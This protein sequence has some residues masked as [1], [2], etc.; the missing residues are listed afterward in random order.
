MIEGIPGTASLPLFPSDSTLQDA[1]A[2]QRRI[3]AA[4]PDKVV[5]FKAAATSAAA[6]T[7]LGLSGPLA[8]ALFENGQVIMSG[9]HFEVASREGMLLETEIGYR[10]AVDVSY[11]VLTAEQARESVEAML[12]VIEMPVSYAKRLGVEEMSANQL[13]AVNIGSDRF[14]YGEGKA[15]SDIDGIETLKA[16]LTHDGEELHHAGVEALKGGQWETLRALMNQITD[17]GLT[18]PAG[19]VILSGALGKPHPVAPGTYEADYGTLGKVTFAVS[20]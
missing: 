17:Q 4:R 20:D 5:G 1:L 2:V 6:Q 7:T 10:I 8:G 11:E 15:P 19:T 9:N 12:P 18:I 13:A 16:R 14:A 3:I